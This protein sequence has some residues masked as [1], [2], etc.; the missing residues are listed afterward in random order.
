MAKG[1]LNRRKKAKELKKAKEQRQKEK[2]ERLAHVDPRRIRRRIHDL[3][4]KRE[5]NN[6][7]LVVSEQ[8]QL[9]SLIKDLEF[10]TKKNL[11]QFDN[12]ETKPPQDQEIQEPPIELGIK[13]PKNHKNITYP[14][15][16]PYKYEIDPEVSNIPIPKSPPPRFF[17]IQQSQTVY[18]SAPEV[19][20]PLNITSTTTKFIPSTVRN[21][22]K[23]TQNKEQDYEQE[24]YA[25]EEEEALGI[26]RKADSIDE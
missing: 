17:K 2:L 25:S 19:Q 24:Q 5:R 23:L 18:E 10:I 20:K 7:R 14:L 6:G 12:E 13:T 15:K 1:N 21:K 8:R 11:S 26:K 4:S 9:D 22:Q 16:T 3:E